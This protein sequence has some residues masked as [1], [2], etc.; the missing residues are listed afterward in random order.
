MI[1]T[2]TT[3]HPEPASHG[4]HDPL[5]RALA[6]FA[7]AALHP[8]VLDGAEVRYLLEDTAVGRLLLAARADGT[9]LAS[10]FAPDDA[11]TDALLDRL[12][13]VVSPSL[14]RGGRA[15]D[16]A[17]R[18][19]EEYLAGRRRRFEL[20]LDLAL[21]TPFQ[22]IVLERLPEAVGYGRTTSYGQLAAGIGRPSA[23]RAVGTALGANPLCV[24]LPC[25]RV[26]AASGALTGYA[27]GLAAKRLLLTLEH[28]PTPHPAG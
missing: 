20:P 21:A 13:R 14:L 8:P 17:R 26:V 27:G 6:G 24:L 19:L 25:H 9:V 23:S 7:P 28:I 5:E 15:L 2:G 4:Q 18:Q 10:S 12:A 16:D 22:R 11:R 1:R 3:H